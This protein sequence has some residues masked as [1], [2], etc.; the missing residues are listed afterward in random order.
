M[1]KFSGID[2]TAKRKGSK[3]V[4]QNLE[5]EIAPEEAMKYFSWFYIMLVDNA[6]ST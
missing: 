1:L 2:L 3:I 6:A 5:A 4:T